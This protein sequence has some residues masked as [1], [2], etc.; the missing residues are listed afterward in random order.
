MATDHGDWVNAAAV[1]PDGRRAVSASMDQRLRLRDLECGNVGV[2]DG[3]RTRNIRNH[4]PGL[5]H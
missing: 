2:A 4:N 3:I 1:M 5:Y